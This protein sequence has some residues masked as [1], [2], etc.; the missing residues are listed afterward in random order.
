MTWL[1]AGDPALARHHAQ[2]CL[3]IVQA[4]GSAP[5]ER[6]FGNEALALAETADGNGSGRAAA[7]AQAREAFAALEEADRGWCQPMLD[8]LLALTP[9][10][11]V[12]AAPPLVAPPALH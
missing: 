10:P 5:L 1:R 12:A 2:Q 9:E 6:F 3:A 11:A 8:K 7:V 4:N